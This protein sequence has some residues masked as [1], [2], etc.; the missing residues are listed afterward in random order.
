MKFQRN[1]PFKENVPELQLRR[2]LKEKT[3]I[4]V[5]TA[6]ESRFEKSG[7]SE[8]FRQGREGRRR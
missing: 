1:Q 8:E 7:Q 4:A 3:S 5:V 6:K 2:K